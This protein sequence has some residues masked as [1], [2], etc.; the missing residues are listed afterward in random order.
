[1]KGHWVDE[2]ECHCR[3]LVRCFVDESEKLTIAFYVYKSRELDAKSM[4][5]SQRRTDIK[6]I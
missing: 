1:M 4:S 6:A 3:I 5:G 2:T